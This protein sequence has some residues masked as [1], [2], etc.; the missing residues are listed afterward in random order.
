MQ[1]GDGN[2]TRRREGLDACAPALALAPCAGFLLGAAL[3]SRGSAGRSAGGAGAL[4][5]PPAARGRPPARAAPPAAGQATCL[6]PDRPAG[7]QRTAAQR[8]ARAVASLLRTERSIPSAVVIICTPDNMRR[9]CCP[10]VPRRVALVH[11]VH[12][13]ASLAASHPACQISKSS[14]G[15]SAILSAF[16]GLY[17]HARRPI[18]TARG[19][20]LA[21][22][23][24]NCLFTPDSQ[25]SIIT[26]TRNL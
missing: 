2:Q 8:P 1:G 12:G 9:P 19:F 4:Q 20:S 25:L 6:G 14:G 15:A 26:T 18:A 17:K 10:G 7:S 5:R 16:D 23:C 24:V 11:A 22:R 3:W 13:S 21:S